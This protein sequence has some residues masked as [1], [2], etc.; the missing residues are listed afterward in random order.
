MCKRVSLSVASLSRSCTMCTCCRGSNKVYWLGGLEALYHQ[1]TRCSC[2]K[3]SALSQHSSMLKSLYHRGCLCLHMGRRGSKGAPR[4]YPRY[5]C[6]LQLTHA[7]GQ[8]C[9][10]AG[11]HAVSYT[12]SIRDMPA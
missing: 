6:A 2:S 12:S 1:S 9:L 5:G 7:A 4:L 11:H 8:R 3:A 10:S